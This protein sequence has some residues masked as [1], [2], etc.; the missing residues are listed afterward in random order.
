MSNPSPNTAPPHLLPGKESVSGRIC[1]RPIGNF[2]SGGSGHLLE[3]QLEQSRASCKED[4]DE[5]DES[6]E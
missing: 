2:S 6:A 5:R 4:G 1:L 3:R